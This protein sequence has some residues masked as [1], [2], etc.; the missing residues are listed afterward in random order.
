M[1]TSLKM[2]GV[3]WTLGTLSLQRYKQTHLTKKADEPIFLTSWYYIRLIRRGESENYI[4]SLACRTANRRYIFAFKIG[5]T[6]HE[7][8]VEREKGATRE[9]AEKTPA[10]VLGV[11]RNPCQLRANLRSPIKHDKLMP[12][13]RANHLGAAGILHEYI[14]QVVAIM[15]WS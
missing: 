6:K 15:S 3:L 9:G 1:V 7:A 14:W 2:T 13:L 8:G 10:A 12:V 4:A 5:R 11:S